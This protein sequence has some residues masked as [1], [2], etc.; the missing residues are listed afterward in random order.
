MAGTCSD[1]RA[2]DVGVGQMNARSL[3]VRGMLVGVVAGLLA[4]GFGRLF[5]EGPIDAAIAFESSHANPGV[6][7]PAL[8]SRTIQATLGLGAAT[9]VYGVALGGLFALAFGLVYGRVGRLGA[10][11]TSAVLAAVGLVTAFVVPFLKYPA[12]PPAVGNEATIGRRSA[13]YVAMILISMASAVVAI[14]VARATRQLLGV[15]NAVLVSA[16]AYLVIVGAAS[17]ILP[18]VNEVPAD[19]S[20]VVL[21]RFRV[22]SLGTQLVLWTALGLL[23]G[24]LSE[25]A[26][27]FGTGRGRAVARHHVGSE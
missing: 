4:F 17:A 13:L 10:R 9:L 2:T 6:H 26:E 24:A 3:V 20:A 7:E 27:L 21:W 12:N 11:G 19:F 16:A 5:G 15:W 22:A 1:S 25:R 14:L 23:F 18:T 8:V